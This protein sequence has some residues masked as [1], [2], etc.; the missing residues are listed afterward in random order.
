MT[1]MNS[2]L[3][4]RDS[5]EN[6][7]RSISHNGICSKSLYQSL[8]IVAIVPYQ[9]EPSHFCCCSNWHIDFLRQWSKQMRRSNGR[10]PVDISGTGAINPNPTTMIALESLMPRPQSLH[11]LN[12]G[13][14]SSEINSIS[15]RASMAMSVLSL[16]QNIHPRPKHHQDW[17]VSFERGWGC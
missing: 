11:P 9:R 2:L 4:V 14:L 15:L 13:L 12:Y 7:F 1:A 5:Y 17:R 16:D 8:T 10:V 6:S 3:S